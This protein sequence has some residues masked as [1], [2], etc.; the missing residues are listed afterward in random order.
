MT[1][2][3]DAVQTPARGG[4]IF[5]QFIHEASC[6]RPVVINGVMV[7]VETD[8]AAQGPNEETTAMTAA[9][10]QSA[11]A[12]QSAA[13]ALATELEPPSGSPGTSQGRQEALSHAC[14]ASP[15][16]FLATGTS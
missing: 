8:A 1:K 10:T 3:S 12:E 7:I 14:M 11:R 9:D 6:R 5:I 13:L 2:N 15:F 16:A 4:A